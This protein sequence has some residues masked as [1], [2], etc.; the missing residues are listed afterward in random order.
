MFSVTACTRKRHSLGSFQS[1]LLGK[2]SSVKYII[3][4]QV[5]LSR[6][7]EGPLAAHIGSFARW[8]SEQGY[9]LCSL[10]RQVRIS[11]FFSRWLGQNG[12]RLHSVSSK[13]AVQYLRYRTRRVGIHEGDAAA[14]R[15]LIQ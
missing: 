15:Y 5:V 2:E 10:R 3:N 9:A 8:V 7:L 4:D 1:T 12:V 13:H 6:P 11:A 14:L